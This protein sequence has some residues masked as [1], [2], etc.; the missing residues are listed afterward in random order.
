M[1]YNRY[2]EFAGEPANDVASNITMLRNRSIHKSPH[3][4]VTYLAWRFT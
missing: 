4:V 2:A 3:N 1:N